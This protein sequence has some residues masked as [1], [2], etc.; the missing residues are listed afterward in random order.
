MA[1]RSP[2]SLITKGTLIVRD[3]DLLGDLAR[4]AGCTVCFSI[5]T[6]DPELSRKLDS[7]VKTRFEEVPAI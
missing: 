7:L 6:M 5:T 2:I 1:W 4:K 3:A